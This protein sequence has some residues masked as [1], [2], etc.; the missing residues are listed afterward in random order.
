MTY[1]RRERYLWL[2]WLSKLM[3]GETSCVWSPWYRVRI[4]GYKRTPSDFDADRWSAMHGVHLAKLIAEREALGESVRR[5]SQNTFSLSVAPGLTLAGR[6]D[7]IAIAPDG[8]ITVYDVRTGLPRRTHVD[9]IMLAMLYLPKTQRYLGQAI[10]GCVVYTSGSRVYLPASAMSQ[11]F[12]EQA[13]EYIDVL[14]ADS[15]PSRAPSPQECR[16]CDLTEEDCPERAPWSPA[17]SP[18]S[19]GLPTLEKTD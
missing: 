12:Q 5:K 19:T 16:L 10:H 1:V 9:Q 6:P 8:K 11:Y 17:E 2:T 14:N 4:A 18:L 15:P 13:Q 3:A 7:L